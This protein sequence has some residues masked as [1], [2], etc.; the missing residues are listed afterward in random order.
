M[1]GKYAVMSVARVWVEG[2]RRRLRIIFFQ[3]VI[4]VSMARA[5]ASQ[6]VVFTARL[7][8][9]LSLSG[10]ARGSKQGTMMSWVLG[11]LQI[12]AG[13]LVLALVEGF[14]AV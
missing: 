13:V 1:A 14:W 3:T 9:T 10:T 2:V 12:G 7:M 8:V 4:I 11:G 6:R 5:F